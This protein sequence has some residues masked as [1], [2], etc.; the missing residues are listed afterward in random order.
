MIM[1]DPILCD[2]CG[3]C[4]GVCPA[5]AV[6]IEGDRVRIDHGRCVSCLACL[7]ICPVGAPREE[8]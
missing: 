6:I 4:V 7:V 1:I 2:V 8:G 5:D 3:T